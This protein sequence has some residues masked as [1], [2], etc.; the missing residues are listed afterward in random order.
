MTTQAT[1]VTWQKP[2]RH[3]ALVI[4][5]ANLIQIV[6]LAVITKPGKTAV[7]TGGSKVGYVPVVFVNVNL[8][9]FRCI[10]TI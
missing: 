4:R 3:P 6:K 1:N 2:R 7:I 10:L 8:K 9:Y 5:N